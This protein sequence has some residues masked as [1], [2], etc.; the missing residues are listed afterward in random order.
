[1]AWRAGN[2]Q[3]RTALRARSAAAANRLGED[4]AEKAVKSKTDDNA[5]GRAEER[6]ACGDPQD[7]RARADICCRFVGDEQ[8]GRASLRQKP[9]HQGVA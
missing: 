6:D 1:M 7:V 2:R 9:A 8:S 5:R 3:A 4:G